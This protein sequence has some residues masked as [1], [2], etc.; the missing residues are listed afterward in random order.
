MEIVTTLRLWTGFS[1][2]A[3]GQLTIPVIGICIFEAE[4]RW[5]FGSNSTFI[6][7]PSWTPAELIG[8]ALKL[9]PAGAFLVALGTYL[10]L[11][12]D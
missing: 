3:V 5:L 6:I 1:L 12:P 8:L 4:W 7:I 10:A 9:I 11:P 2:Y